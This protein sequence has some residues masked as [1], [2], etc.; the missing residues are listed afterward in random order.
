M[1]FSYLASIAP[2]LLFPIDEIVIGPIHTFPRFSF[3]TPTCSNK[4]PERYFDRIYQDLFYGHDPPPSLSLIR[5]Y[6]L[7]V[8]QNVSYKILAQRSN[9]DV[10]WLSIR[11]REFYLSPKMQLLDIIDPRRDRRY[12]AL[13]RFDLSY[14]CEFMLNCNIFQA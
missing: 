2:T 7:R 4:K 13:Y 6:I 9:I 11:I 8:I 1:R 10:I 12:F 14:H 3:V 5:V